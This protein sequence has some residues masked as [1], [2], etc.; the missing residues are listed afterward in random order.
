MGEIFLCHFETVVVV[1]VVVVV[2]DI[3]LFNLKRSMFFYNKFLQ[4]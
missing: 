2:L 1:V 3:F 4:K